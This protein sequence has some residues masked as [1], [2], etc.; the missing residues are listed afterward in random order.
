ML[1]A[2][3]VSTSVV[4]LAEIGDKTQLLSLVLAAR[5]R[6]PQA[7]VMGVLTATLVNHAAAGGLGTWL[8][9]ALSPAVLNWAVVASFALMAGWVLVPDRLD[10]NDVGQSKTPMGVFGTTVVAFFIAE[11]GD[12]TQIATIALAARYQQ[13]TAVVAGTTLAMLIANVPVIYFGNRF[14]DRLPAKAVHAVAGL[15]FVVLGALALRNALTGTHLV[16]N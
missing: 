8:S 14:A 5:Y 2:F 13:F 3:L 10:P 7:I 16:P 11:M 1:Q 12:K 6:K 15:M 9:H 4:A